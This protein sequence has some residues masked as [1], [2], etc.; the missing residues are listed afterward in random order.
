MIG[1]SGPTRTMPLVARFADIWN[2]QVIGPEQVTERSVLLDRLLGAAGR[3]PEDVRRTLNVPILCW[4][5]PTELESRLRGVR[6]WPTL[7]DLAAEHIVEDL[8]AWPALVG[9]PEEVVAQIRAFEAAGIA[10]LSLQWCEMDDIE[11]LKML[12][13]EVLPQLTVTTA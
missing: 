11:G 12:A 10:E 5:T 7:R 6:R 2:A 3:W 8:R 1:G 9:T 4:R 13:Q